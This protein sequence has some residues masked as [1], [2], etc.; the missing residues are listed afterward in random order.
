M[1]SAAE[2]YPDARWQRC[3]VHFYRNF[4]SHVPAAKLREVALM[5]KAIHAQKNHAVARRKAE[6]VIARLKAQRLT[7][8]AE[9]VEGAMDCRGRSI[10]GGDGDRAARPKGR[11]C[12]IPGGHGDRAAGTCKI[13]IS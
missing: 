7:K 3:S 5:L 9:L 12:I 4:F 2:F 1:A 8:A 11:G 10:L 13:L 6:E